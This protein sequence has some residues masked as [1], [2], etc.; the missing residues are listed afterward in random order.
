MVETLRPRRV[1]EL[2]GTWSYDAISPDGSL[3]MTQ[4][5]QMAL[6]LR[7]GGQGAVHVLRGRAAIARIDTRSIAA[8]RAVR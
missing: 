4:P 7:M 5:R 2:S 8:A 6:R 1:V 3:L